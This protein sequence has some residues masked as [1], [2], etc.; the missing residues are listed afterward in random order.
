MTKSHSKATTAS[1]IEKHQYDSSDDEI[2]DGDGE[3]CLVDGPLTAR[4]AS[5]AFVSRIGG[6][7]CWLTDRI[8]ASELCCGICQ[9]QMYLLLQLDAPM[10]NDSTI[11]RVIYVFG[12][13]SRECTESDRRNSSAD[14]CFKVVVQSRKAVQKKENISLKAKDK[15][16]WDDL[17]N[18][19]SSD[20]SENDQTN[21]D[22]EDSSSPS[23]INDI[24][25]P[26]GFVG[27]CLSIIEEEISKIKTTA[28]EKAM[29][30]SIDDEADDASVLEETADKLMLQVSDGKFKQFHE[31]VSHNPRQCVRY[32]SHEPLFFGTP[33]TAESALLTGS[34]QI[35]VR[36]KQ[37]MQ[38]ELQLMPAMLSLLPCND[39][40]HLTHIP[41]D[42]RNKHALLGDGM[43]WGTVLVYTCSAQCSDRSFGVLVQV[44]EDLCTPSSA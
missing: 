44:E 35:C 41:A 10:K 4:E 1:H 9:S 23:S 19:D 8:S 25:Y 24:K 20:E 34:L 36:C 29:A 32:G 33:S 12:C 40:R 43:E 37:A 16:F 38:F 30:A 28:E 2:I 6:R 27:L 5:D 42:R 31:R 21:P 14:S 13:N 22:A 26:V 7:P 11:D 18:E 15:S 17:M 39:S 3:I